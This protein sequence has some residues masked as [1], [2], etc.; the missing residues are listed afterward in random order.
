MRVTFVPGSSTD[1]EDVFLFWFDPASARLEQFAYSFTRGEGGLRFRRAF[2]YRRVGGIL[3]FDQEN[4]GVGGPGFN[5][6]DVDPEFVERRL[7]HVS[8]VELRDLDVR[9]LR[10]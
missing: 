10:D 1:A 8:T 3:F 7:S 6:D 5:V 9:R 2:N 4:L